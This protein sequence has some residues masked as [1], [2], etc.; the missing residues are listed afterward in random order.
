MTKNL[1]HAVRSC[2]VVMEH[3]ANVPQIF[4]R[5]TVVLRTDTGKR[6][7]LHARRLFYG[8]PRYDILQ[9]AGGEGDLPW[10]GRALAFFDVKAEATWHRMVLLHWLQRTHVSH[11]PGAE[12]FG[13][14]AKNP[15]VVP[16]SSVQRP[17]RLVTSPRTHGP[18]EERRF[19]LLPY[20]RVNVE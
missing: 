8:K 3:L 9:V 10:Y 20:G 12:T 14:W 19:V 15:D 1:G 5:D 16:L 18:Q 2:F 13:Y 7:R 4:W 6:Y 17:V 11:V